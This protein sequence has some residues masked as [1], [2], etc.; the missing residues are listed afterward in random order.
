MRCRSLA[1]R[2]QFAIALTA[3]ILRITAAA[4]ALV[5]VHNLYGQAAPASRSSI[6]FA[7]LALAMI[8]IYDL[9]LY[10]VAYLDSRLDARH[11]STGAGWWSR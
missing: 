10:T 3:C 5:L 11:C 9:N 7:M 8:W 6:R 2:P 4:G 1:Q